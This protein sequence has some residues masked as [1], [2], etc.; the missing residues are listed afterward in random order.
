MTTET[1]IHFVSKVLLYFL[2][3]FAEWRKDS[4]KI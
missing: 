4:V 3:A 1:V 2:G